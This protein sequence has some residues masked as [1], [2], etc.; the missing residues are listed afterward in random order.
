[1]VTSDHIM[2]LLE[3]VSGKLPEDKEKM[4]DVIRTY[5]ELPDSERLVYRIGRRG[6][7]YRSTEDLKRD[8]A[9]HQKLRNLVEDLKARGGM[10]EVERFISEMVDQ[11][12]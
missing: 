5:Q 11:Y 1:M 8:P 10:E 7:A 3:E 12:I 6:G 9:T 2:N 4:L